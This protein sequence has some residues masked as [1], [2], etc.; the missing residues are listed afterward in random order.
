MDIVWIIYYQSLFWV[1]LA[2]FPYISAVFPIFV[3][4]LFKFL[5]M[6]MRYLKRKPIKG[7]KTHQT[8]FLIMVL[9]S[10]TF[11][12]IMAYYGVLLYLPM[13]HQQW[14]SDSTRT[15]GPF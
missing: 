10:I 15:C 1:S 12:L 7:Y 3:Y 2:F 11:V 9:I 8:G 13:N 6:N 14:V 5:Y 4:L